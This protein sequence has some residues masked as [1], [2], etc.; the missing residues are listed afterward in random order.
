MIENLDILII[1]IMIGMAG[2]ILS[3][4]IAKMIMMNV[5]MMIWKDVS[6]HEEKYH[7]EELN[8]SLKP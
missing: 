4:L 2:V 1:G 6:K 7:A 3:Y 5:K 8:E